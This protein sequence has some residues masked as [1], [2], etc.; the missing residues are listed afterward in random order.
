MKIEL[1]TT[2]HFIK[3][4]EYCYNRYMNKRL[5]N[6]SM[7]SYHFLKNKEDMNEVIE[8][9]IEKTKNCFYGVEGEQK[10]ERISG[11]VNYVKVKQHLRRLWIIYK[12]VYR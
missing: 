1:N 2:E 9:I 11:S 3:E 5:R 12:C 8:H 4:A 10:T 6:Q 7:H